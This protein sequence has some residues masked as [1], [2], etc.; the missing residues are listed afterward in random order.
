MTTTVTAA[1]AIVR[2]DRFK[3]YWLYLFLVLAVAFIALYLQTESARLK[4]E[5]VFN[6]GWLVSVIAF[7]FLFLFLAS[8]NWRCIV[9]LSSGASLSLYE[10]LRQLALVGIGKY[11]PGKVWGAVARGAVLSHHGVSARDA[12]LVTFHEQYL[13]LTSGLIVGLFSVVSIVG[14][15]AIPVLAGLG[16]A[17]FVASFYGQAT[18]MRVIARVAGRFGRESRPVG[19]SLAWPQY[20]G[21]GT[22]FMVLW[23]VNGLIFASLYFA[24]FPA[25]VSSDRVALLILANATGIMAGF[26]ALFAPAG[27]G[28]REGVSAAVLSTAMPLADALV[29]GLL[30]RLW[31]TAI[32]LFLAITIVV[33]LRSQRNGLRPQE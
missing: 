2:L 1:S 14:V 27:V 21:L 8:S 12:L 5:I 18:G 9:S 29:L 17:V 3:R 6:R 26:L 25:P 15:A 13:L 32:D 30:F 31:V 22:R 19:V 11:L 23:I 7:H 16:A 24:V 20:F 4:A 28:V 10:S 33:E